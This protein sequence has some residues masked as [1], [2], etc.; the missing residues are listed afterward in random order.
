FVAALCPAFERPVNRR[1]D[2]RQDSST[3]SQQKRSLPTRLARRA[4]RIENRMRPSRRVVRRHR[5]QTGNGEVDP[6]GETQLLALKP[7]G[8]HGRDRNDHGFGAQ[9]KHGAAGDHH[10]GSPARGGE[11][12]SQQAKYGKER[13]R[14][15]RANAVDDDAADQQGRN[16]SYA[17]GRVQPPERGGGE[18]QLIDKNAF[19][20]VDAVVNVVVAAHRQ[21]D[22]QQHSPAE[23]TR[24]FRSSSFNP[25]SVNHRGTHPRRRPAPAVPWGR[26]EP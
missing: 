23:K 8:E 14:L 26:K 5:G 13:N 21:A 11:R 2:N 16:R 25:S 22:K 1:A 12:G 6:E 4:L 3:D 20:R 24:R 9:T 15:L 19:Q 17:I 18:T 7:L 10:A